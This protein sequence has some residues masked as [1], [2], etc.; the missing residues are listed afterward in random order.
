MDVV[1]ISRLTH[2]ESKH[3]VQS[4]LKTTLQFHYLCEIRLA[5]LPI[6]SGLMLHGLRLFLCQSV[7]HPRTPRSPDYEW[8][9]F[10]VVL[11]SPS[12]LVDPS[13]DYSNVA[14][15]L[16]FLL[17]RGPTCLSLSSSSTSSTRSSYSVR[18]NVNIAALFFLSRL[19][20]N[21]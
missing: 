5:L 12:L 4:S 18:A 14:I 8:P 13:L 20:S 7:Q 16:L 19:V 15:F 10:Y 3:G 2:I 9:R 1:T 11:T 21:L 17:L 6:I